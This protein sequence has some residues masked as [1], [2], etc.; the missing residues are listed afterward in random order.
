MNISGTST[1]TGTTSTNSSDIQVDTMK[2]SIDTQEQQALKIIESS[3]EQSKEMTA[4]KTG[5]GNSLNLMA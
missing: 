2:K 3:T 1:T 4:Q 5:M